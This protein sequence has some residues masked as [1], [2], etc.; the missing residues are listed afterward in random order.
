MHEISAN[1]IDRVI[2]TATRRQR[3]Q[4]GLLAFFGLMTLAN[5]VFGIVVVMK[6]ETTIASAMLPMLLSVASAALLVRSW[7]WLKNER[8]AWSRLASPAVDAVSDAIA[9]TRSRISHYQR[10]RLLTAVVILPLF[11]LALLQL[12][13]AGKM[14]GS[15]VA[16]LA[17]LIMVAFIT[18]QVVLR[19]RVRFQLQPQVQHLE[20]VNRQF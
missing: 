3:M 14:S 15:D 11:G 5:L 2:R 1:D 20:A 7:K 9:A 13:N 8:E 16:S 4:Q 12:W 17:A 19:H 10:V 18:V 6:P